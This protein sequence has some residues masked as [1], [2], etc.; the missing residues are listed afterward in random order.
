MSLDQL[1]LL[2]PAQQEAILNGPALPPPAGVVPNLESPLNGNTLC[3][4]IIAFLFFV[5]TSALALMIYVKL[6]H[7][8]RV[9]LEDYLAFAGFG[10]YIGQ[11]YCSLSLVARYGLFV[12]QWEIRVKDLAGILYMV[13]IGSELYAV[14]IVLLKSAILLEWVRIFVPR[15]TRGRFYWLCHT[16]MWINVLFYTAI[17]IAGNT[18]CQPYAKLWDKTLPGT[19]S[20]NNAFDVAT[21]IY[22]F[23]SDF[24]ILLLP[25]RVIW[26][27]HLRTPKKFGIAIVFAIG[28]SACV[29]AAYR[30]YASIEFLTRDDEIYSVA[31]IALGTEAEVVCATLVFCVPMFP[32]AFKNTKNPF[33]L[34]NSIFS[35]SKYLTSTSAAVVHQEWQ[36][37]EY[38]RN[39]L[40]NSHQPAENTYGGV[41]NPDSFG[42]TH[43]HA[44]GA[45]FPQMAITR[46]TQVS[47]DVE[48]GFGYYFWGND[49]STS[50]RG[51]TRPFLF[52]DL[53]LTITRVDGFLLCRYPDCK[54]C[55]R[56][57]H[58]IPVHYDCLEIF[59]QCCIGITDALCRLWT[60]AAWRSPWRRARPIYLLGGQP[61]PS[62]LEALAQTCRMQQ[63]Y[64]LPLELLGII[65]GYSEHALL[66]RAIS[67][68]SVAARILST[69]P[70]P[71]STMSLY[72]IRFW[73]RGGK[74]EKYSDVSSP[75]S[76]MRFTLD[77]HGISK[78]ERTSSGRPSQD[79]V[80]HSGRFAYIVEQEQTIAEY[81][82]QFK[83]RIAYYQLT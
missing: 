44:H 33:R 54:K 57:P 2:P 17:F 48:S 15:A 19:C 73:E 10:L 37:Q 41:F 50:Y 66:W 34:L 43:P 65:Q 81:T 56:S 38:E 45:Y 82:A 28:I 47:I 12:H 75:M 58:F 22:N 6:F 67:A 49:D 71:L 5:A 31:S 18:T 16:L 80:S 14:C 53:G 62:S 51:Q 42:L 25:Q 72:D 24:L 55:A 36:N 9:Y 40:T 69:N 30:L 1:Y 3:I 70:E 60:V 26:R 39:Q 32:K 4:A 52:P 7:V 23:I 20:N 27:L 83:V 68:H 77:S 21:A 13:H 63:L 74:L 29:A 61:D 59:L 78:I 79:V 76:V 46:T 64:K 35:R 11:I 8:K